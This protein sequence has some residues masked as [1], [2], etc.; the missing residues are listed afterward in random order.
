MGIDLCTSSSVYPHF[1]HFSFQMLPP[2]KNI[3]VCTV[4]Y[5]GWHHDSF[6]RL[7]TVIHTGVSSLSR[8]SPHKIRHGTRGKNQG[9][10]GPWN[11]NILLPFSNS[12]RQLNSSKTTAKISK[13]FAELW[14]TDLPRRNNRAT[15]V[16]WTQIPSTVTVH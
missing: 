12:R 7:E 11:H 5:D 4:E 16:S 14:H 13:L 1:L 15:I 8:S 3:V 9:I 2:L 10:R 6:E